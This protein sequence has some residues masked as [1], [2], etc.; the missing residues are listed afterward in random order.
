MSVVGV[1]QVPAAANSYEGGRNFIPRHDALRLS[2][3]L[4]S[5][6]AFL[7]MINKE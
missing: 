5:T 3:N 4:I 6:F 2:A 1:T 7:M